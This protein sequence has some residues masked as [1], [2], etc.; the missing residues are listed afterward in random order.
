[1]PEKEEVRVIVGV[2]TLADTHHVA[3]ITE[4]GRPLV[5]G[6]F[7]A[8]GHGY[9]SI[10]D[11]ARS[12]GEIIA[13]GVK[14]TGSYG[15]ALTK[16]LRTDGIAVVE[17]NRPTASNVGAAASPIPWMPMRRPKPS[18]QNAAQL[19]QRTR[20]ALWS[21]CACCGPHAPRP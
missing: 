16:V 1:M 19:S 15:A 11:F 5:D 3:I 20:T 2:D 4:H 21:V 12:H 14:C 6:Q 10:I 13:V 8:T 17:V 7:Q 9:R 18:W